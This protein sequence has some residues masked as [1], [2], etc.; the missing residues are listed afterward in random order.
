MSENK[1]VKPNKIDLDSLPVAQR[2]PGGNRVYLGS[3]ERAKD[4]RGTLRNIWNYLRDEQFCLITTTVIVAFSVLLNLAGPYLLGKAIDQIIKS[5]N[6]AQLANVSVLLLGIYLL[7]SIIF[8]FEN[9]IM[10]GVAQRTIRKIR[11]DAFAKL[12]R[13]SIRYFDT[14]Q[15]GDVMS[16]LINDI[17]N[18]NQVLSDSLIQIVFGV[19]CTIGIAVTMVGLN[20]LLGGSCILT[21]VM[22]SLLLNRWVAKH[23]RQGFREQQ[24][25]LGILNGYI[26]ETIGGQRVVKIYGR[27]EATIGKF[28]EHS[29]ILRHASVKAQTYA[30]FVGPVMDI[31]NNFALII[32]A[33]GG[34][35]LAIKGYV[36]VGMIATFINYIRQFNRPFNMMAN[37]YNSIQ[38]AIAG[39]ERVFEIIYETEESSDGEIDYND[40][41]KGHVLFND[42]SFAYRK[43]VPVL[44][45]VDIEA[46]PGQVIALIGPTGAGKTTIIN[47]L[48]RFYEIDSG[49]ITIDGIDIREFS[50]NSLRR[51]LGIVLQDT[52]LFTGSILENIRY[53]CLSATDEEIHEAARLAN[54]HHFIERLPRGYDTVVTDRGAN[55]SHGQRQLIA[56]ARAV[57]ADPRI[58]ILDEATSSVDTR[59]EKHIQEAMQRLMY[60]RTS[61][62]IAHRLSTIRDADMIL[63]IDG[64][65]IL[66]RGSHY[67][68]IRR[69]GAYFRFYNNSKPKDGIS[70]DSAAPM[71]RNMAAAF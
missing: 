35:I 55:L 48:T 6:I 57:L 18:I 25:A 15:D 16:R 19:L 66:E 33:G 11:D 20:P 13:L 53:G 38:S 32:V 37:L 39:A 4:H 49:Q 30:G 1:S 5:R 61:F 58:L 3:K 41:V 8:Y 34:G 12:Q 67:E 71:N 46:K 14:H 31:I 2:G 68:L 17:E 51:Q 43:D 24:K 26:E 54:V 60:G 40:P 10:A 50:K 36:S 47:L 63:V 29:R 21:I 7:N 65:E 22:L 56:I 42:V 9:F 44:R 23:T 64:G 69:E 70:G 52:V 62:V 59:T 27:E 45:H 28:Q